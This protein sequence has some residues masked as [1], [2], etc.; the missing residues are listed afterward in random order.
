MIRSE[1]ALGEQ[2]L[3]VAIEEREN[4]RYDPTAKV[5]TAG[6]KVRNATI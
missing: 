1:P 6:S 4:R 5:I 3:D 2:F